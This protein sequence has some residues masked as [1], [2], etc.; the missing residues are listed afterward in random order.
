MGVIVV[1]NDINLRQEGGVK[2]VCVVI[3]IHL[4]RKQGGISGFYPGIQHSQG[5]VGGF[6]VNVLRRDCHRGGAGRYVAGQR[7]RQYERTEIREFHRIF[8]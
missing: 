8:S 5:L 3:V 6:S 1:H 4:H 7:Q 2:A